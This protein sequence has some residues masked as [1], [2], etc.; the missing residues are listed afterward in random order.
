MSRRDE[1]RPIIAAI[2]REIGYKDPKKLRRAIS[3]AYP[4][5]QRKY[6]PY[7]AWL[8]EIKEQIGGMRP[9]RDPNQ[10]QLFEEEKEVTQ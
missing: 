1:V 6:W 7:R 9:R 5:A 8:A 4:Y 2:V 10:L 3:K